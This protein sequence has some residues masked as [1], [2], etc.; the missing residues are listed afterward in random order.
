MKE[1]T[2]SGIQAAICDYL[3]ARRRCFWRS[4]NVPVF[5]RSSGRYRALPKHT[6]RGLPDIM[7]ILNGAFIG[8]EVKR[9]GASQANDQRVFERTVTE[10]GGRYHVV[11]SIEDVQALGL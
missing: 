9:K 1:E 3:A 6:P 8:L 11:H 4:N 2:E 7:V 10:A 5:D